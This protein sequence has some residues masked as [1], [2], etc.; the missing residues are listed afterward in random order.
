MSA[1]PKIR[2]SFIGMRFVHIGAMTPTRKQ[3]TAIMIGT[4]IVSRLMLLEISRLR[5]SS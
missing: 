5:S 1:T 4:R 2:Y 3:T